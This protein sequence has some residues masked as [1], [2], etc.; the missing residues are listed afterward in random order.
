MAK[1]TQ[2]QI[3]AEITPTQ[4]AGTT[5]NNGPSF[6]GYFAQVSGGAIT[7]TVEKTYDG[8]AKFPETLCA[9]LTIGDITV[10]RQYDPDR[11][12]PSIKQIRSMVGSVYYDV[13]VY[14]LNCD[15]IVLGTERVYPQALLIGL[16]EP[17]GDS[18]SGNV[19][20]FS[21]A[22]S[23]SGVSGQTVAGRVR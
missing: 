18:S 13:L 21:L 23:I 22:F 5:H 10:T 17:D 1:S 20:M 11:D 7:A 15:L 6:D 19:A 3:V 16:T 8:G 9:P 14:D 4:I 2:R 12:G